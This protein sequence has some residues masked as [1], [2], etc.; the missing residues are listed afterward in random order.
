MLSEASYE[1]LSPKPALQP[2]KIA[3]MSPGGRV[4]HIGQF[5]AKTVYK[6]QEYNFKVTVAK[7]NSNLLSRAVSEAMGLINRAGEVYGTAGIM[8]TKPVH[9]ELKSDA[10]SYNLTTARRIPFP[11]MNKV[12][13]ELKRM[14][15]EGII[16][17]VTEATDWC[18]PMV[19][20]VKPNGKIRVCVD[21]KRLNQNVKRPHLMLPNLEDFAPKL[22]GA[23]VFSTIDVAS[24]FFQ[25]PLEEA[26][27]PLT[28]F[29]TPFGRF[30]FT[31]VPMGI[32]LGPEEFQRKMSEALDNLEG[33]AII[34]DDII[35]YG[36][37]ASEHDERLKLVF[38]KIED[39]GL[40]LNKEK[41]HIRKNEVKF[42][43]T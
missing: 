24:G 2:C 38:D 40:K 36:S 19:P 3:L 41:C 6:G 28:T 7:M 22:A 29:I 1:N 42:F 25:V 39:V 43:G 12:E 32:N 26:S 8:K 33:I 27:A 10:E 35:V 4:K 21:F 31:R 37:T 23:R 14:E 17:K 11:L 13:E 16:K 9:I 34:M 20:V 15:K 30:C 18:A 5:N